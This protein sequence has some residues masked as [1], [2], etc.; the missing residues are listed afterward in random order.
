MLDFRDH[1][2]SL[3]SHHSTLWV[4]QYIFILMIKIIHIVS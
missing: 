3:F 2:R 1:E 4:A